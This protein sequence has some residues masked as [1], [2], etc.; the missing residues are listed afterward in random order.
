MFTGVNLKSR[1]AAFSEYFENFVDSFIRVAKLSVSTDQ[2]NLSVS[3]CRPSTVG[4]PRDHNE[5]Y[6]HLF[7]FDEGEIQQVK[8]YIK[9]VPTAK[10]MRSSWYCSKKLCLEKA[11]F[12]KRNIVLSYKCNSFDGWSFH[13]H[14]IPSQKKLHST[15]S[16]LV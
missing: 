1:T 15:N 3:D 5:T 7:I 9:T 2:V 16:V 14:R 6:R 4:A 11:R 8:G 12:L 10:Y 13:N